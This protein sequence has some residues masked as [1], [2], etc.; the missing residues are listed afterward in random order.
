MSLTETVQA[1]AWELA[2][3]VQATPVDT[4][5]I[6]SQLVQ[7]TGLTE[8][9]ITPELIS[10]YANFDETVRTNLDFLA[11]A[12]AATS[13]EKIR[14]SH[15]LFE[16]QEAETSSLQDRATEAAG[17]AVET[18]TQAAGDAVE[19]GA[20]AA[21]SG[22][23][24]NVDNWFKSS[25]GKFW[26][27]FWDFSFSGLIKKFLIG[28]LPASW[29]L[30]KYFWW[31]VNPEATDP[32]AT[33]PEAT[34]PEATD[35]EATDPEATD[36]EATDPENTVTTA[37]VSPE[38]R[39]KRKI[40]ESIWY[41]WI[42]QISG[43]DYGTSWVAWI[44][45]A[46]NTQSMLTLWWSLQGT[47]DFQS[48]FSIP[49]TYSNT[50]IWQAILWL[51]GPITRSLLDWRL[52]TE[53][54]QAI[55]W[56]N[57]QGEYNP[58]ATT[59]FST[60]EL[61][62]IEAAWFDY[63]MIPLGIVAR[64]LSLS[65]KDTIIG[66]AKMSSGVARDT[67]TTITSI[68]FWN[69]ISEELNDLFAG[70]EAQDDIYPDGMAAAMAN[71]LGLNSRNASL[72][73]IIWTDTISAE[74]RERLSNFITF[75]DTIFPHIQWNFS[76]GLDGFP[77]TLSSNITNWQMLAL[78]LALWGKETTLLSESDNVVIY[79]WVYNTLPAWEQWSYTAKMIRE[80]AEWV[81]D[82][83]RSMVMTAVLFRISQFD[84][85]ITLNAAERTISWADQ[86]VMDQVQAMLPDAF[87]HDQQV[88]RIATWAVEIWGFTLLMK[89]LFKM[90]VMRAV[91]IATSWVIWATIYFW[92]KEWIYSSL[93]S[94]VK[95]IYDS[96]LDKLIAD[97]ALGSHTRETLVAWINDNSIWY[98]QIM[99]WIAQVDISS[100]V[101]ESIS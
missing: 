95:N 100:I 13:A 94:D 3:A 67:W 48:R 71:N 77:D 87:G 65:Y 56:R 91:L 97:W 59:Y 70:E 51:T 57:Q 92:L 24:W 72:E 44:Y 43:L 30:A 11:I 63:W 90:P 75:R 73:N 10:R 80:I 86:A 61:N 26:E 19:S 49:N 38:I 69:D 81:N 6:K 2:D 1:A 58:L 5:A 40:A 20:Q 15:A 99:T 37:E 25:F 42:I 31:E 47:E 68:M 53:E 4:D 39:N 9:E 8:D 96:Y 82:Q 98:E 76:L 28:L 66:V 64:L 79:A 22:I 89:L 34:D 17:D 32:E 55:L 50:S 74:D 85:N 27:F 93:N 14:L 60:E 7:R 12:S 101:Q 84:R 83:E 16:A 23:E 54:I 29:G 21:I 41:R 52:W 62:A 46:L 18:V 35:P 45:E 36:P 88:L 33:D 78:F